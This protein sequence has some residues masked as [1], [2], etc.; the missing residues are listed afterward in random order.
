MEMAFPETQ[1]SIWTL[2]AN[3]S[4]WPAGYPGALMAARD[5]SSQLQAAG[6]W[7][8]TTRRARQ[9]IERADPLWVLA[10]ESL[11]VHF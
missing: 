6:I 9:K 2:P 11:L 5:R 3:F 1:F 10:F 8:S 4:H 7:L